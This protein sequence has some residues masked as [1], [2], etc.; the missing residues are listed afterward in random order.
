VKLLKL[1]GVIAFVVGAAI[2]VEWAWRSDGEAGP[3]VVA[4][5]PAMLPEVPESSGLAVSRRDPGLLWT[6]N[7]S[8]NAAVL[9]ALDTAGT[10]RG[11]V[12]VPIRTRDWE[13]ISAGPCPSGDCL[14]IAD[15]GDNPLARQQIQIYRVPEPRPGDAE[16]APPEV[17]NATY[18]D[19]PHNAEALFVAGQDLFIVTRDRVAGV[20]RAQ[21]S[22]SRDLTFQRIGQLGLGAVTDAETSRDGKSVVVR[23]S[24]EAVL[25]RTSDLIAGGNVP[26]LRIPIDGLREAQGEG[27]A[28]DGSMLYLSSEGTRWNRAGRIVALRCTI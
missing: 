28:L 5:G 6:H 19:G 13:D 18:A 14:Y 2:L 20:Y 12:R 10:V 3:C 9:F 7:D 24:H 11:R 1:G 16:T 15:I 22:G 4:S 27:V 25:Y 26:Y 23:T 8:G 21:R 17:F